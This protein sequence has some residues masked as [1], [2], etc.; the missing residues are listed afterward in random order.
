MNIKQIGYF[1]GVF[2]TGSFSVT[3]RE[4]AVTVQAVSKA[5]H[6]LESEL[7]TKLFDRSSQGVQPTSVGRCFYQ[8]ARPAFESFKECESFDVS[9][10]IEG[11]IGPENVHLSIALCT[12]RFYGSATLCKTL[13]SFI[14]R[15]LGIKVDFSNYDPREA[16]ALLDERALDALVTV[17][18]Y[19]S[20]KTECV[21]VGTLPTGVVVDKDH[22]LAKKDQVGVAELDGYPAGV[23]PTYDSFNDS[24]LNMY[25][26][27]GLLKNLTTVATVAERDDSFMKEQ[28]G[29]FFSAI[30]P[31]PDMVT[32]ELRLVPVDPK[33]SIDI[34]ICF[35]TRKNDKPQQCYILENFLI[36][37]ISQLTRGVA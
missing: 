9:L 1:V 37:T 17:G 34:S 16:Q 12:P 19:E 20:P 8:K 29:F 31:M 21:R 13:A 23:S 14:D 24:I 6:E 22:P 15:S 35:V 2:E 36:Q 18:A 10:P 28:H 27:R 25:R 4:R 26:K 32:P 33:Q 7:T 11:S 30:V 3:A 5:I